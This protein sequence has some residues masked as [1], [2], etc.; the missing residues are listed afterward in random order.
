LNLPTRARLWL[1]YEYVHCGKYKW[2]SR[3]WYDQ[4]ENNS[5]THAT[6]VFHPFKTCFHIF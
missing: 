6:C 5:Y 2:F 3:I 1:F 4:W